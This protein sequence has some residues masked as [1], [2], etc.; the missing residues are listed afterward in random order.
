MK[1]L[2]GVLAVVAALS[3]GAVD[4]ASAAGPF[5]ITFPGFCDCITI[6]TDVLGGNTWVHG[7][8]DWVCAGVNTPVMGG[9]NK[10][11]GFDVGTAPFIPSPGGFSAEFKF[12]GLTG[13]VDLA[14]STVGSDLFLFVD[15]TPWV[16]AAG[17]CPGHPINSG[18]P[19]LVPG[20]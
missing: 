7:S 20:R 3:L 16:I 17:T 14:A 6:R 9:L 4:Q 1:K 10:G 15:D 12:N 13:L 19:R 8:W 2:F 5:M 11:D 18:K